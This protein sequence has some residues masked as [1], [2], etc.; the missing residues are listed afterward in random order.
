MTDIH[1]LGHGIKLNISR[2]INCN[3]SN[4]TIKVLALYFMGKVLSADTSKAG[5]QS[6]L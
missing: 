5:T 4:Y 1:F 3:A 2:A 6:L